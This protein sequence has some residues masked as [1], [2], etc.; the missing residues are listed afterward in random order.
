MHKSYR[1]SPTEFKVM[2]ATWSALLLGPVARQDTYTSQVPGAGLGSVNALGLGSQSVAADFRLQGYN[3]GCLLRVWLC[4]D[5]MGGSVQGKPTWNCAD[6]A[7]SGCSR[8]SELTRKAR[9]WSGTASRGRWRGEDRRAERL[10]GASW[11]QENTRNDVLCKTDRWSWAKAKRMPVSGLI[12]GAG[13]PGDHTAVRT[14]MDEGPRACPEQDPCP[15][16]PHQLSDSR[17]QLILVP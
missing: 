1:K 3:L 11:P 7:H 8:E 2:T 14:G 5:V 13:R 4:A 15:V 17:R 16:Y 12:R 6:L 9:T 10:L